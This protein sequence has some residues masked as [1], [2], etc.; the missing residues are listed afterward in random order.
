MTLTSTDLVLSLDEVGLADAPRAGHKAATLGELK[1]AGFPVPDGMVLDHGRAGTDPGLGRTGRR[2]WPGPGGGVAAARRGDG[3]N[4][5]CG[6]AAGRRTAGGA[7]LR[8]GRGP[9]RRLLRRAVRERPRRAR[10]GAGGRGAPLLGL[11]VHPPRRRLPALPRGGADPAMA[12]LVQ[13]MVPAEAAGVAF[14]ADPVTGDRDAAVVNAVRGLGDRLV[15]GR[16]RPT[17][18][19]SA[20]RRRRAGRRP[21]APSPPRSRPTWPRSPGGLRPTWARH[22]TSS[23]PWPATRWC[24]SRRGRSPPFPTRLRSR[25]RCRS[26]CRPGSGSGRPATRPNRG[27]R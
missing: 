8:G 10:R 14:T 5:R 21:R 7:F 3:R 4:S 13:P 12:V 24:C 27:R 20:V 22:R 15:A 1:R 23:G 25:C 16:R 9:A 11:G 26:R 19:W 2:R 17:S 18:G 6:R